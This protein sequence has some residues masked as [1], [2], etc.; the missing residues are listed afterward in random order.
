MEFENK[1]ENEH[2]SPIP[3]RCFSRLGKIECSHLS[4]NDE[5]STE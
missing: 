3:H 1:Y 5:G 2:N 4:L